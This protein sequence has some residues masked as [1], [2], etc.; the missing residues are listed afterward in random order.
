MIP[1]PHSIWKAEEMQRAEGI[2]TFPQRF[3]FYDF[4]DTSRSHSILGR[5]SELIPGTTLQIFQAVRTFTWADWKTSP[6]LTVILRVLQ[7]VTYRIQEIV[8]RALFP[9][10]LP[11]K[12]CHFVWDESSQHSCI[13][14]RE[15]SRKLNPGWEYCDDV[16]ISL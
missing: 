6:L 11:S 1:I 9:F 12:C 7:Y 5:K 8:K 10:Y 13:V 4:T 3:R 16:P 14:G 2:P 15:H